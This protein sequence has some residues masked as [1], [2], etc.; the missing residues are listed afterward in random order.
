[1]IRSGR[2]P[3]ATGAAAV[4]HVSSFTTRLRAL[5]GCTGG[6]ELIGSGHPGDV[7]VVAGRTGGPGGPGRMGAGR[8]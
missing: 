4:A 6:R 5:A 7:A 2:G 3:E 1:M 8:S